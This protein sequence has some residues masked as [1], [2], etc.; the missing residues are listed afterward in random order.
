MTK[1]HVTFHFLHLHCI[2]LR[3][4]YCRKPK[5]TL[6]LQPKTNLNIQ[7]SFIIHWYLQKLF[8]KG[9]GD[10]QQQFM[11]IFSFHKYID[12]YCIC[13]LQ[14]ILLNLSRVLHTQ[15]ANKSIRRVGISKSQHYSIVHLICIMKI[16]GDHRT[17]SSDV[18]Q[19]RLR[20]K[21]KQKRTKLF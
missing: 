19:T 10:P 15:L 21:R 12:V 17:N 9:I 4:F 7:N 20:M 2:H 14:I 11:Q 1:Y 6:S 5:R 3:R 18:L 8:S 13:V 16:V